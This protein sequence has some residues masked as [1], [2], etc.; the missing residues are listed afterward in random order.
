MSQRPNRRGFT[1]V[2]LLVVIGIIAMLIAILLPTLSRAKEQANRTACMSN[3]RQLA[4]ALLM[5]SDENKGYYPHCAPAV[6][7]DDWIYW[8]PARKQDDGRLVK[9][10][11]KKFNPK[12]YRCPSDDIPPG[13]AY[14]YSYTVN[15]FITGWYGDLNK[16]PRNKVSKVKMPSQKILMVDE[17]HE[18][19][20]DGAWAPD[21][22]KTDGKNLLSNRHDKRNEKSTDPNFGKGTVVFADFHVEFFD[23]KLSLDERYY[24]PKK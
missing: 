22:Y 4:S 10:M 9:Y 1:L 2:E 19:I 20:D 24:H 7:D 12:V 11:G 21:H 5:Y 3:L 8:Q 23:R 6:N 14:Q 16:C 15:Y 18:T 17:S 13:R